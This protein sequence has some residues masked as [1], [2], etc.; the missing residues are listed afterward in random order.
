[1]VMDFLLVVATGALLAALIRWG[2]DLG[3]WW[4]RCLDCRGRKDV[5]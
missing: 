5:L 1:M 4:L 3:R 2:D